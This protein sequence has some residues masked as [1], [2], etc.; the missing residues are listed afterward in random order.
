MVV[1]SGTAQAIYGLLPVCKAPG[2][3]AGT[4]C[5]HISGLFVKRGFNASGLDEM[6]AYRPGPYHP[7]GFM[8]PMA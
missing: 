5:C 2:I 6:R 7:Y 1:P 8:E 4:G 3:D